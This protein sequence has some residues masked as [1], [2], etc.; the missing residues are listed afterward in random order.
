[1][2]THYSWRLAPTSW[3][4]LL[5]IVLLAPLGWSLPSYW[6]WENGPL[7]NTQVLILG[8]GFL[9]CC[10]IAY[11]HREQKN[12]SSLW[13]WIAP[14]WLICIGRELSWGRVFFL[15]GQDQNGPVFITLKQ[16]WYGPLVKPAIIL[17]T[18]VLLIGIFHSSP[19]DYLKKVTLPLTDIAIFILATCVA[20]LSDKGIFA[21]LQTHEEVV[22]EWA[23]IVA[24]WCMLSV[25]CII[26]FPQKLG[27]SVPPHRQE[28]T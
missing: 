28:H 9:T 23:E 14:F 3:L 7:E 24:Y 6:G 5:F 19:F 11:H 2:R 21:A 22:E 26:G 8:L 1:M 25:T 13:R 17:S 12:V 16:L 27:F 18:M 15:V 20:T 4:S 10:L